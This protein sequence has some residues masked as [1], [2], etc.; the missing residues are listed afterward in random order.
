MADSR[1]RNIYGLILLALLL[2]RLA[3]NTVNNYAFPKANQM[4]SLL[5]LALLGG[6][7]WPLL[8]MRTR[9]E[10]NIF[11]EYF[12]VFFYLGFLALRASG[13]QYAMKCLFAEFIVWFTFIFTV[14]VCARDTDAA[15]NLQWWT[16]LCVRG[17]I[18]IGLLQFL[19]FLAKAGSLSIQALN[20]NDRPV[21]SI[22]SHENVYII[23][24][25]PFFF[26]FVK[27]KSYIW[28][29][30]VLF[31]CYGTGT[32]SPIFAMVCMSVL[33]YCSLF[34]RPITWVH[35][36]AALAMVA[37]AYGTLIYRNVGEYDWRNEE[38]RMNTSTLAWRVHH[39]QK[40]LSDQDG[41]TVWIGHGLGRA[42][43][44]VM[45]NDDKP[46]LPHS[47]YVRIFYDRGLIGL[48]AQLG[49]MTFVIWLVMRSITPQNDYILIALLLMMCFQITD[50]FTYS[51][52]AVW[53]YMFIASFLSRPA[54]RTG[55]AESVVQ[56]P[57]AP[58]PLRE[59]R[60]A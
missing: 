22:F 58:I 24:I 30:L 52:E 9:R 17:I 20:V 60:R 4:W 45:G 53:V 32:R 57:P 21:R 46:I 51:T 35:L 55:T 11:F 2:S 3:A 42:D 49:L 33:V 6:L 8:V 15:E 28:A 38:S 56:L 43:N 1:S 36:F 54:I 19:A 12:P 50:N 25:L 14:E 34:R 23:C 44:T 29:F 40:F 16:V 37:L 5:A 18:L 31:T 59:R 48:L 39:W 27:K 10:S 41:K 7:V 13:N 47:D 26:Y